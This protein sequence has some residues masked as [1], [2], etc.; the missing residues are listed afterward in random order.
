MKSVTNPIPN[1]T[2]GLSAGVPACAHCGAGNTREVLR[3]RISDR[4]MAVRFT[5]ARC[6]YEHTRLLP[7]SGGSSAVSL[8]HVA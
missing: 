8:P 2:L 4:E 3:E 1:S 6:R 5:C 7:Y